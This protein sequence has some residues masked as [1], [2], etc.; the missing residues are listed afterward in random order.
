MLLREVIDS[1]SSIASEIPQTPIL[2]GAPIR[3]RF[4][5]IFNELGIQSVWE[6]HW[7]YLNHYQ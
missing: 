1:G 5:Q 7:R 2:W 3:H 6:F 4:S